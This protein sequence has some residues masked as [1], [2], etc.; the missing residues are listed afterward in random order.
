MIYDTM[1]D[2]EVLQQVAE[3]LDTGTAMNISLMQR[4][5]QVQRDLIDKMQADQQQ[6]ARGLTPLN[7]RQSDTFDFINAFISKNGYPPSVREIGE[8]VGL[9]SSSTVHGHLER[10]EKKG[11]IK[12]NAAGG[13]PRSLQITGKRE[14]GADALCGN[15]SGD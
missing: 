13:R 3:C 10:L 9:A 1:T 6:L 2:D 5:L 7:K 11:Y 15:R 14:V 8:G 4:G 12:R